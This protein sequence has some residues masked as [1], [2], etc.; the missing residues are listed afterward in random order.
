METRGRGLKRSAQALKIVNKM[1]VTSR[2]EINTGVRH[3]GERNPQTHLSMS[4]LQTAIKLLGKQGN[5][6]TRFE[7]LG[8][9]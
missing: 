8:F 5:P 4:C 6:L 3:F 1:V 2:I 7:N 9:L